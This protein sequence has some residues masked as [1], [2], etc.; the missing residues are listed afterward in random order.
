M[1]YTKYAGLRTT[2][3]SEPI[4]GSTQVQNEAGG[5]TWPVDCWE[6]ARR[7]L[8][9]GAESGTYYQTEKKLVRDSA[10]AVEECVRVNGSR[11]V[12][13]LATLAASNRAPKQDPILFAHAMAMALGDDGTRRTAAHVFPNVVRTQSNLTRWLHF[14][15]ALRGRGRLVRSS[16]RRWLLAKTP[17]QL[18]YQWTKYRARDGWSPRDVLR[19]FRPKPS[20]DDARASLYRWAA[21]GTPCELPVVHAFCEL[22]ANPT[23]ANAVRLIRDA[24]L[25]REHIP[26]ELLNHADV[27]EALAAKMPATALV[28][29]LGKMSAVGLI[30]PLSRGEALVCEALGD[31]ARLVAARVNPLAIFLAAETYAQRHGEKGK[32]TWTPSARVLDALNDA[33]HGTF[34]SIEPTGR[35]W[36]IAVDD[37]GSMSS[38]GAYRRALALAL[39]LANVETRHVVLRFGS[40]CSALPISPKQRLD[41]VLRGYPPK[42]SSTDA[43]LP[44]AWAIRNAPVLAAPFDVFVTLS[45]N[46]TWSGRIHPYQALQEYRRRFNPRARLLGVN[47]VP[48]AHSLAPTGVDQDALCAASDGF[49]SALL[50]I[51]R[52]LAVRET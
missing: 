48:N 46:E 51:A 25:V 49:D 35:V 9:L 3:Q 27:W 22:Q 1:D 16:V 50:E 31:H 29:N 24:G 42:S 38:N 17:E 6:R 2:P 45:D 32:L 12:V 23:V 14:T 36:C 41:D 20:D 39:V 47:I 5:Y 30:S 8:F 7:F 34:A 11:F 52:D 26:T 33:F 19:T 21:K 43:S 40:D 15:K 13:L 44:F 10:K 4:L 37:S 18:A 28:R